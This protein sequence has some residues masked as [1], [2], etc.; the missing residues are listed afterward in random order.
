[1]KEILSRECNLIFNLHGDLGK[2][3]LA[4]IGKNN[5]SQLLSVELRRDLVPGGLM[6]VHP[7]VLRIT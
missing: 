4:K 5:K 7:F 3:R 1:M 2:K 6:F